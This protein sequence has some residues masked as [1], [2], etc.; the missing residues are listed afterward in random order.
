MGYQLHFGDLLA[1]KDLLIRGTLLTLELSAVA[2][3]LG[4]AVGTAGALA[5]NSAHIALRW[6]AAIYV[7]TIRNTPFIVQL[8]F[9]YFGLSAVG[10]RLSAEFAALLAMVVNLGAYATEIVRAGLKS[11]GKGQVEAGLSIG[12]TRWQIFRHVVILP[13]LQ[14]IYPAL[15]SQAIIVMLGSSVCSQISAQELTYA[16]NFIQSRNFRSFEVYLVATAIYFVLTAL[17][18]QAFA[19]VGRRAFRRR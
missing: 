6:P 10:V 17:L 8:F 4:I 18:R 12:L 19:L 7:E 2:T 14:A 15:S 11:I 16:A 9:L 5:R 3:V 1:Y 13:A